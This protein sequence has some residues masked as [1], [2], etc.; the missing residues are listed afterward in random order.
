MQAQIQVLQYHLYNRIAND[1]IRISCA[2]SNLREINKMDFDGLESNVI[3]SKEHEKIG[4]KL[5][6]RIR[7]MMA[8][9]LKR[10]KDGREFGELIINNEY[11]KDPDVSQALAFF[12]ECGYISKRTIATS[13]E[14][15]EL[16]NKNDKSV[17]TISS[18]QKEIREFFINAASV[19]CSDMHITVRDNIGTIVQNRR[20]S[21]LYIYKNLS[22]EQGN[23]IC[24]TIYQTMCDVADKSFQPKRSQNGRIKESFLPESLTG[25]RIATTPTENGYKLVA[26][27]LYRANSTEMSLEG[28]GYEDFHIESFI[29]L[30]AKRSGAIII[31][32]P[33]GSGKSTTLQIVI[34]NIITES[35]GKLH[36]IT[37]EDPP[38]YE[39]SGTVNVE[40]IKYND[41][42]EIIGSETK[43]VKSFA[44]QIPV[45]DYRNDEE[46]SAK[47]N[48][49][50]RQAMRLDP[51]IMMIGEIRDS[52]SGEA[53]LRA[54]MTGH[55][56][57]TTIHAN[58][59]T[60][61]F[62]RMWDLGVKKDLACD[63]SIVTGLIAQRLV[64]KL[65]P[66]CCMPLLG[67]ESNLDVGTYHRLKVCF[68]ELECD[69]SDVMLRN[70]QGC[71]Y[72]YE[73]IH[74][75]TVVAEIIVCDDKL[76]E[77]ALSDRPSQLKTYWMQELKG[78]DMLM[79]GIIKIKRGIC[80][81]HEIEKELGFLE[82]NRD[83]DKVHFGQILRA[84]FK[85]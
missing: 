10:D 2:L 30:E 38:E 42:R 21:D 81:P 85:A 37:V 76:M 74:N 28:L 75:R 41:K 83:A 4:S 79:H 9:I 29:K 46:R 32:G 19:G 47:Y 82:L 16:Y 77:L 61:I 18:I 45:T 71:E 53:A 5:P 3:T 12:E 23:A 11:E 13:A 36:V 59:A 63:A 26:R 56:V 6:D 64:K 69:L 72:C 8:I 17:S 7:D 34:S 57:Y 84:E 20:L 67:N 27:L 14:I 70:Y 78:I 51:D 65:C 33:T 31:S 24:R 22:Y 35:S 48:G 15:K 58:N 52:S 39:I 62:N 66:H 40:T 80:D 60:T 43:K 49:A 25:V 1:E 73:G 55:K 68:E 54:S 44:T 50:I